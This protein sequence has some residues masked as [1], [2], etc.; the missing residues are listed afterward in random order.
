MINHL[1]IIVAALLALVLAIWPASSWALGLGQLQVKSQRDQPLL[2]EI[3]IISN[4]PAELAD[5]RAR[6]ASAETFD[7]IGLAPPDLVASSLQFTVALDARGNPVIRVTSPTPVQQPLVTFLV[8]V[9]WGQGRLVREYSAL[10]DT[11]QT[12]A[13]P[14]QPPIEAPVVADA[15]TVARPVE[16]PVV[17]PPTPAPEPVVARQTPPTPPPAPMPSPVESLPPPAVESPA[18]VAAAAPIE[19]TPDTPADATRVVR[20]GETLAGIATEVANG[21]RIDQTIL[22]LLRANPEAFIAG[23][24]H[25]MKS[26]AVLRI[27]EASTI[28]QYNADEAALVMR[29]QTA[30]WRGNRRA[31]P[32]PPMVAGAPTASAPNA[33][34]GQSDN[35]GRRTAQ[36]RLEIV[37]PSAEEARRAGTRS[38]ISAGGEGD[39]L[40]EQELQ[41]TRESLAARDAEVVELKARV[42]EL[43]QLQQ[44]QNQL[45]SMKDSELAAAQQRLATTQAGAAPA[46]AAGAGFGPWIGVGLG[47]LVV[48]ALAWWW[49]RRKPPVTP[50]STRSYD[51]ER[52]AASVPK[53]GPLPAAAEADRTAGSE[54][55]VAAEPAA[56]EPAWSR[57]AKPEP[58]PEPPKKTLGPARG[59]PTWHSGSVSVAPAATGGSDATPSA[60]ATGAPAGASAGMPAAATPATPGEP[61][62][63]D[64]IDLARA[65][66]DLGDTETARTLL[67]EVIVMGDAAAREEAAQVL[68]ELG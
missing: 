23:N 26:G 48:A 1:R 68:R 3:P 30:Q 6:L 31:L 17:A 66:L 28:S 59:T 33:D 53:T 18:P 35:A 61:L 32:Q 19:A 44:K 21:Q 43:E 52:L 37:P 16:P 9:N 22:A 57:M 40:R 29:E 12:A 8:E 63:R 46:Q 47:L 58:A 36:A 50:A 62:G 60:P 14:V 10:L 34:S 55:P 64:R 5:L 51:T 7:R 42:A 41:Q 54:P 38:G 49:L 45:I 13:A 20:P 11:P 4:D 56:A 27:P 39:M 24:M 65:Y 25:R 67:R 2:A 15:N